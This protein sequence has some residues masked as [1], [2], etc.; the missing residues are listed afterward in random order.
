MF[1]L[2][3][4]TSASAQSVAC[5]DQIN[6]SVDHQCQLDV[7]VDAF[8]EGDDEGIANGDYVYY[9]YSGASVLVSGDQTGQLSGSTDLSNYI[10]QTLTFEVKHIGGNL[11]WGNI[12][13]E[14]KIP[15]TFVCDCPEGGNPLGGYDP[16]CIIS[17]YELPILQD[18]YWTNLINEIIPS[19]PDDILTDDLDDN[20]NNL[21]AI[22]LA[23]A[24]QLITLPGCEGSILKRTW[25]INGAGFPFVACTKEYFIEPQT[26]DMVMPATFTS[27]PGGAIPDKI[28]GKVLFPKAVVEIPSCG[29]NNDPAS[30]AAYFDDPTTVDQD[31]DDNGVDPDEL[32][33]DLVV[34]NN[35]GIWYAYPHYYIK[36]RNP[37]GPHAQAIDNDV[38]TILAGYSDIAVDACAPGCL[39]NS[40]TIRTWTL[41]DWCTGEY[42]TYDQVIKIVDGEGPNITANDI[43]IS[44]NPWDCEADVLMPAPEHLFD[45]CDN[46]TNY[47]VVGATPSH[48]IS[49]NSQTGYTIHNVAVGTHIMKYFAE[50]CCGNTSVVNVEVTVVDNTPP[51][52]VS[53]ESIVTSLTNVGN[54][55][56]TD[57]GISKI[58]ARDLDNGS[59]DGCTDVILEVRRQDGY[60][61]PSDTIWGEF[62]RFCCADLDGVDHKEIPVQ[63]R[64]S[65]Y[66]GNYN[67]VWSNV[68]LEDKASTNIV[69]PQPMIV[70]CDMDLNDFSMTGWPLGIGACGNFEFLIEEQDVIDET[71]ARDKPAS[72]PPIYDIDGDNVPDLIP[73][74]S[75]NCGFGAVRR[76]FRQAGQLVCEQW[77]VVEPT[78]MF[79]PMTI[80]FPDNMSVDCDDY[81]SGEPTW[82][83]SACNLIG[84]SVESDTFHMEQGS[85]MTIVNNWTVLDWCVYDPEDP[86]SPGKYAHVQI[87]QIN[88]NEDPVLEVVDSLVISSGLD[89]KAKGLVLE[90]KATDNGVCSSAWIGWDISID[91]N[92]DWTE[93]YHYGSL[94]PQILN[95]EPN[96]FHVPKSTNG[97]TIQIVLPDGLEGDKRWHRAVW[98]ATDGCN[99]NHAHTRYF[100][101]T[102]DKA[103]TPYCLN[104]STAFMSNGEVELWAIDFNV[105]SFDNCTSDD[106]LL[107]TFTPTPPPTRDDTEY[108]RELAWYDGTYWFYDS[109]TG[110]YENLDDYGDDIHKWE[111][112]L[113]SSGKIFTANDLDANGF[114]EVPVYVWDGCAN[115]DFCTVNLRILDNLGGGMVAGRIVTQDGNPIEGIAAQL[116]AAVP[117]YPIQE[118]TDADGSFAFE[119]APLGIDYMISGVDDNDDYLNGVSTL[120]I[121]MIQRHILG[122]Q[123][124]DSP[125]KI[126]A[127]DVNNDKSITAVDLIELRKLILGIYDVLPSNDSWLYVD[128]HQSLNTDN[129]WSYNREQHIMNL[130]SDMMDQNFVALKV[131]D[132]NESVNFTSSVNGLD[133]RSSGSQFFADDRFV[134]EGEAFNLVLSSDQI[135]IK[136]FQLA[137]DLNKFELVESDEKLTEGEYAY[138]KSTLSISYISDYLLDGDNVLTLRLKA[139]ENGQLSNLL[140]LNIQKTPA[141]VIDSE[142]NEHPLQLEF[143]NTSNQL[144]LFQN[145]PN[146]FSD[147]SIIGFNLPNSGTASI[148]FFDVNGKLL[149][150]KSN[151]FNSGYNE[152]KVS[153]DELD[154]QGLIYYQINTREHTATKH[155]IILK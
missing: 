129:A 133:K 14:D 56:S 136:A 151:A 63:I 44:V 49:G 51:V 43:T 147:E 11:C 54:P 13:I 77:F 48:T 70:R 155:M 141:Q 12:L 17:C 75:K 116:E 76:H 26:I 52:A 143:R 40:K 88:D 86:T 99:N 90:A 117:G 115:I 137:L 61:Y 72:T 128:Q 139:N 97:E 22:N 35:E 8:L 85:C 105:G 15:P 95:G 131:G 100:Q 146:P 103:P 113:R 94:E 138:S 148:S 67:I 122:Q 119:N 101:V 42:V 19:D 150:K 33:I 83:A 80:E 46:V 69:C 38:C 29:V 79:D 107:F 127:A 6:V 60:C 7:T 31:T 71:T 114:V 149:A 28:E 93:D 64:I 153:S 81:D 23:Y 74:Y 73:A 24:D 135:D 92:G 30:I 132:V 45:D 4:S 39:G 5:N 110:E 34:E 91:L 102:D 62:V 106:N 118:M 123:L 87:I 1:L 25:T 65:D 104:L 16:E 41:L 145:K 125:F 2:T 47:W 96:P 58:F 144:E 57:N 21:D 120:D 18:Q 66:F 134:Q 37:I 20:C 10:N 3:Y 89:C 124:L 142:F 50:D 68:R 53:K 126:I 108:D 32:D 109:N 130:D 78:E 112:G 111:P 152:I 121:I 98:R 59:Y 27:F 82:S 154:V 140:K 84:F 9:V 36:G 55:N